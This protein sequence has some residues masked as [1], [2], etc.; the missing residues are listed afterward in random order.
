MGFR[1]MGCGTHQYSRTLEKGQFQCPLCSKAGR[2]APQSYK[3]ESWKTWL[4][5]LWIPVIPMSEFKQAVCKKCGGQFSRN[6]LDALNTTN[7]ETTL[8]VDNVDEPDTVVS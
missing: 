1:V 4:T 6:E 2:S 7:S 3:F 8:P 5:V